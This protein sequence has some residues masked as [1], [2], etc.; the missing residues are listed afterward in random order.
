MAQICSKRSL[1]IVL[2]LTLS[3]T[4]SLAL[5]HALSL[6]LSMALSLILSLALSLP[7]QFHSLFAFSS[8]SDRSDS[9]QSHLNSAF[10]SIFHIHS[11]FFSTPLALRNPLSFVLPL[12]LPFHS[13]SHFFCTPTPTS[14]VFSMISFQSIYVVSTASGS[15]H[16]K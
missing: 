9:L 15:P 14:T 16:R 4:L 13:L 10:H 11:G 12:P 1:Q 2:S 3:L 5:S 8:T 7:L 6:S